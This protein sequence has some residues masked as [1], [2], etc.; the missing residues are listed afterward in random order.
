M[1]ARFELQIDSAQ[2]A[3]AKA[4]L[5]GIKNG[6]EAAMKT[7]INRT[8]ST[9]QT[10]AVARIGNEL[11]LTAARIKQDFW[12]LNATLARTGGGVYSKG[13][14]IGLVSYGARWTGNIK[15]GATS[16][17]SVKVKRAGGYKTI[18][19]AF[20]ATTIHSKAGAVVNIF[21]RSYKGG[22]A[23]NPRMA[24]NKL[25]RSYRYPIER[26][27]GPRIQDIY[28]SDKVFE[29][30]RIQAQTIFLTNVDEGITEVFRKLGA[31]GSI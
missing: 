3:D 13:A 11:N 19:H 6:Y 2:L 21:W 12:I 24:Y 8:L 18:K 9:V 28:A 22:R 10:Q 14:P 29:P 5:S 25:P 4:A 27:D 26:L 30:V 17:V 20:A 1:G 7:A 16:N 31:T 15:T 23:W